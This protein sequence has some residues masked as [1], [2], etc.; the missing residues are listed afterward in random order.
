M[1]K[2]LERI[3]RNE[4]ITTTAGRTMVKYGAGG[5][6]LGGIAW[7]L[8]FITLPYLLVLVVVGGILLQTKDSS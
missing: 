7:L 5:I 2:E 8:P 1:S 6:A 3:L 4:P